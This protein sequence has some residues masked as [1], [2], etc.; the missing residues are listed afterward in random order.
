M[1]KIADK[2]IQLEQLGKLMAKKGAGRK[3]LKS[4][5]AESKMPIKTWV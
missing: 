4:S 2:Q 5:S 1:P 3:S